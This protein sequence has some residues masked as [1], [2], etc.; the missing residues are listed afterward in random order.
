MLA[1]AGA[2]LI[3][4]IAGLQVTGLT[5]LIVP[6]LAAA[7]VGSFRSFALTLLG[8]LVIGILQSEVAWLQTYL[9]QQ[10]GHVV[11]L[12]GWA[13]TVPFLVIII[14][15]VVRGRALPL[16]GEAVERPPAVGGGRIA[17]VGGARIA[18]AGHGARCRSCSRPTSSR[19][20]RRAPRS[21]VVLLSFVVVTGY[22]G[23]L[24]LA[25]MALAGI[26][27]WI[28]AGARGQRRRAA[29]ARDPR[30]HRRCDPD[31]DRSWASRRCGPGA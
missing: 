29:R 20:S 8:G 2:I 13:E 9:T 12:D 15:L 14:V 3:V 26:G 5:L 11:T 25:Q 18:R 17:P 23:Q 24:S 7:L 27:A 6:A 22:A 30:R 4:N 16:R 28:C 10:R 31:R 1:A 21:G 19:R